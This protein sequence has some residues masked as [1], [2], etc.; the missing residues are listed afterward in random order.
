MQMSPFERESDSGAWTGRQRAT[1]F[2]SS[3]SA[4]VQ[5][6]RHED[7]EHAEPLA[8][9]HPLLVWYGEALAPRNGVGR[10]SSPSNCDKSTGETHLAHFYAST[11]SVLCKGNPRRPHLLG[12]VAFPLYVAV[13][14]SLGCKFV[15]KLL[16]ATWHFRHQPPRALNSQHKHQLS[17]Q[18]KHHQKQRR[19]QH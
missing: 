2:A 15:G 16:T 10:G 4:K 11:C 19:R 3:F 14:P 7:R 13:C 17:S 18:L 1:T 8:L 5:V 12:H 6:P 9:P